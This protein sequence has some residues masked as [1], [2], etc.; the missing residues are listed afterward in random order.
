MSNQLGRH[1]FKA[2]GRRTFNV[3]ESLQGKW[4]PNMFKTLPIATYEKTY[5]IPKPTF[6]QVE[7]KGKVYAERKRIDV[8]NELLGVK[9]QFSLDNQG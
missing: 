1:A 2:T 7:K 8:A 3:V 5:S 6:G 4:T 9:E